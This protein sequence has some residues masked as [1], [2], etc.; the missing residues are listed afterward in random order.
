MWGGGGGGGKINHPGQLAP[1]LCNQAYEA[2][3]Q[4]IQLSLTCI[5]TAIVTAIDATSYSDSLKELK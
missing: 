1:Q 3:R 2:E 5:I 4:S